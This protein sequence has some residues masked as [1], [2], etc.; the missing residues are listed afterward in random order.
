[1]AVSCGEDGSLGIYGMGCVEVSAIPPNRKKRDFGTLLVR[2]VCDRDKGFGRDP[3]PQPDT[4]ERRVQQG[5]KLIIQGFVRRGLRLVAGN[6]KALKEEAFE[7]V[8]DKHPQHE[9][10]WVPPGRSTDKSDNPVLLSLRTITLS[11]DPKSRRRSTRLPVV[12][13]AST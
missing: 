5:I 1:M 8:I 4:N 11:V 10:S 7:Q 13:R 3:K 12:L 9:E 2:W 6:G